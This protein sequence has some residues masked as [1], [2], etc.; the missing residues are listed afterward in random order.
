MHKFGGIPFGDKQHSCYLPPK[1]SEWLVCYFVLLYLGSIL[2][3][4]IAI[5]LFFPPGFFLFFFS[6][7]F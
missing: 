6:V 3:V 1:E 5:N 4:I 7:G 2:N